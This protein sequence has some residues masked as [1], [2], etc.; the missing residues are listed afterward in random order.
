MKYSDD[1]E[2]LAVLD[3]LVREPQ[4]HRDH[5]EFYAYEFFVLCKV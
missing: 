3:E 4:M 5:A 1:A 2:A